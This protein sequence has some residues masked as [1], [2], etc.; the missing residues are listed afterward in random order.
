MKE[1]PMK[2]MYLISSRGKPEI[3]SWAIITQD[4]KSFLDSCLTLDP[5]RRKSS[6]ELLVHSFL[7][8]TASLKTITPNIVAARKKKKGL[9]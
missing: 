3:K 7:S 5:A 1:T 6:E 4:F 8:K 2:A 9:I